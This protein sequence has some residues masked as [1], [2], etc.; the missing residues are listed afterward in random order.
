MAKQQAG[1]HSPA[2]CGEA[3][4]PGHRAADLPTWEGHQGRVETPN[5]ASQ[6]PRVSS[7]PP[8]P[9]QASGQPGKPLWERPSKGVAETK[10]EPSSCLLPSREEDQYG[11][12]SPR[13]R[14]LG[15]DLVLRMVELGSSVLGEGA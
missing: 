11:Y 9:L 3:S 14:D 6:K 12:I 4:A 5:G 8:L 13:A 15:E 2:V 1:C 10:K 7:S